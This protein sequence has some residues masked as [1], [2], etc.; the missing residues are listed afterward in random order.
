MFPVKIELSITSLK[1]FNEFI[2]QKLGYVISLS[3]KSAKRF[4]LSDFQ[5][6]GV[7]PGDRFSKTFGSKNLGQVIKFI[8]PIDFRPND[9]KP[10]GIEPND[11]AVLVVYRGSWIK[12]IPRDSIFQSSNF[13]IK[14]F[15][16]VHLKL[17]RG[18]LWKPDTHT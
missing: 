6:N 11:H 4:Q 10:R 1:L 18:F 13:Y 12:K 17:I 8:K 15:L 2:T 7:K 16:P 3:L 5:L 9:F 14:G